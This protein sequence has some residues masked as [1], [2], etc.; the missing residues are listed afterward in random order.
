MGCCESNHQNSETFE[1]LIVIVLQHF[2]LIKYSI[3][4]CVS[5]FNC[6][7]TEFTGKKQFKV[8][9]STSIK[10]Y[11]EYKYNQVIQT[12]LNLNDTTVQ[13]DKRLDRGSV[14][15]RTLKSQS[16][17][18]DLS[19]VPLDSSQTID[20]AKSATNI[21]FN[22]ITPDYSNLFDSALK[23]KPKAMFT[24]FALGFTKDDIQGKVEYFFKIFEYADMAPNTTN[25][26][27]VLQAFAL[28]NLNFSFL[29]CDC[30]QL[31]KSKSF[32]EEMKSKFNLNI[33]TLQIEDWLNYNH[34]LQKKRYKQSLSFSVAYSQMLYYI[35]KNEIT[36]FEFELHRE[37][38]MNQTVDFKQI[39]LILEEYSTI[40]HYEFNEADIS[41]LLKCE[42]QLFEFSKIR[43]K[44]I[45]LD[46]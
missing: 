43:P 21:L 20:C 15:N 16:K 42:P 33:K 46:P 28:I 38:L 2:P 19:L 26:Q 41:L 3:R 35:L 39:K 17:I 8:K 9:G 27:A 6:C 37:K 4:E 24:L 7:E 5:I 30:M 44:L 13:E 40:N 11:S 23:N 31:N 36:E 1:Q 32:C 22:A 14:K 12:L 34:N 18:L 10:E 25:F 45:S 29:L